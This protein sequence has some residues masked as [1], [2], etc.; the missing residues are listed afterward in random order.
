MQLDLRKL[1]S[2]GKGSLR[3]PYLFLTNG[4]GIPESRRAS[5]LSKLLG[6]NIDPVQVVQGHSPFKNLL[7]RFENELIVATGKG[8]PAVV[9]S[10]Y[11]FKKV[12]SL[13]VYASY[14]NSIDPL[15]PYKT[16]TTKQPF[17]EQRSSSE[18]VPD[19]DVTS[20]RVKAAFV[21]SD[22]VDWSRD[23]QVD[24]LHLFFLK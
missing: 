2:Y 9:M 17:H 7:K 6:V 4:G 16:W 20:E 21:V 23:I 19:F 10:E 22:P 18:S 8:E 13:D 1:K 3:I 11:G 12:I 5:D 15:S 24:F 14:F